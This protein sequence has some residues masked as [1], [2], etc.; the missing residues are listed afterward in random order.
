[1]DGRLKTTIILSLAEVTVP[2]PVQL[3]YGLH[4]KGIDKLHVGLQGA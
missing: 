2:W 4:I 1:M 3:N